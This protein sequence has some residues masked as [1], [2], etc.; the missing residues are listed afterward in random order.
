MRSYLNFPNTDRSPRL[1]VQT[2]GLFV[3]RAF[4]EVVPQILAAVLSQSARRIRG[5]KVWLEDVNGPRGGVDI[6]CRIELSLSPRG[7]VTATSLAHDEYVAIANA[8]SRA[9]ALI[10]SRIKR[11]RTLRRR[12]AESQLECS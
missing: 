8:A 1:S 7:R 11:A 2:R 5:I 3:E 12:V 6:R 4:R 9:E 10:N